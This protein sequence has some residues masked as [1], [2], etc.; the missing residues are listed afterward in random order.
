MKA[1]FVSI[2]QSNTVDKQLE[3]WEVLLDNGFIEHFNV[4]S[5]L[6]EAQKL[7]QLKTLATSKDQEK[8][9]K[10]IL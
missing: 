2:V 4:L 8:P 1:R 6:T 9:S 10:M 7:A 5:S 3:T